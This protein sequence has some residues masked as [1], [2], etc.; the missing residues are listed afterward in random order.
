MK[1]TELKN[2]DRAVIVHVSGSGAFRKRILEMGFVRG[3]EVL[4]VQSAPLKDPVYY[5]LMDYNVSLRR[6]DAEL[7]EVAPETELMPDAPCMEWQPSAETIALQPEVDSEISSSHHHGTASQ[8]R[9]SAKKLRIALVGNPNAGK[10]SIFNLASGAHEHVGNYSGVTVE[11]KTAHLTIDQQEIE[12]IDLPGSYSLS[13][14]SPEELYIRDYLTQPETKPDVVI[15]VVDSTN[16]ERNLYLSIQLKELGVPVVIAL[17]MFDEFEKRGDQ[18][19]IELLSQLLDTPIIPTVGRK[20][21]GIQEL[22]QAATELAHKKGT[23]SR[24]LHIHYGTVL[25]PLVQELSNEIQQKLPLPYHIPPRYVAIRLLEGDSSLEQQLVTPASKGA[26]V[27]ATRDSA[28]KTAQERLGN[29]EVEAVITDLRYGFIAGALRETYRPKK[30]TARTFTAKLDQL[31]LHRIWGYPIFLA[32]IFVMFQSTFFLGAYPEEWIGKGV[33]LLSQ[34]IYRIMPPGPLQD[35]L[36]DGV[37][38]GVGGV[39]VFLPYILI[40][41][42]FISLLEDT[43]YMSR[44]AFLMDKLMHK[45]GLHGKSF[46]PLI[47]GFG[48]NVPAVMATRTIESHQ[49]RLITMLITPFMS[50]SARLPV[51]ILLAGAFFP[52]HSGIVLFALYL[53]GI[54]IAVGSAL[55]FRKILFRQEDMPFV[56]ELPPFRMPTA[57]AVLIHMWGKAKL[58]LHKM[59]TI[60][61]LAS[62]VVWALG[63]FPV[64]DVLPQA[65]QAVTAIEQANGTPFSPEQRQLEVAMHAYSIQQENSYLGHLG[66]RIE[67]VMKPLGMD[68]KLSVALLSGLPAKEIVVTSI[69][70]LYGGLPSDGSDPLNHLEHRLQTAHDT[71]GHLAITPLSALSFLVFVSLYFPCI[72]TIIAISKEGG[73]WKWGAL[74]MLYT[75]ILAW[76]CSWIVYQ[77]GSLLGWG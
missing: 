30:R 75:T 50:C 6:A 64:H 53:F 13:P 40:L 32:L 1:L 74:V 56:M 57:R 41:Y 46:I 63:Y 61:L 10:T 72:A 7:I 67:P 25:E 39:L 76:I 28:L 44:A 49:S 31:L 34:W 22:F 47:M 55:L 8:T 23:S 35:L 26:E 68:W 20:E 3:R 65:E 66:R 29:Q 69:A 42:L 60:I 58:Y 15:D 59:A 21:R 38:R 71:S 5:R 4:V 12:V 52:H 77:G 36:T 19:Q 45:M 54:A 43:G 24:K 17:N 33:E 9:T 37:I 11:A 70:V 51:Y 18:L 62:I 14:Y 27:L 48:C 2:G 16:L 73:S